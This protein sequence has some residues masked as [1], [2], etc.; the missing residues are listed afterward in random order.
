MNMFLAIYY[1]V[2]STLGLVAL[3]LNAEDFF[4]YGAFFVASFFLGIGFFVYGY[5]IAFRLFHGRGEWLG[6]WYQF[7]QM[8]SLANSAL[9][10]RCYAG[11]HFVLASSPDGF[12]VLKGV[13]GSWHLH[14]NPSH[15]FE[16]WH[17][18]IVAVVVAIV[19]F[20]RAG[21][22]NNAMHAT[23]A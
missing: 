17:I 14:I 5:C 16:Y 23:R 10:F 15:N 11:A 18:N 20:L 8:I 22:T 12:Q 21:K 4:D 6:F 19:H 3:A 7:P 1:F 13:M 2:G 9:L